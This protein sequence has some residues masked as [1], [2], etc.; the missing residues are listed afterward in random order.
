MRWISASAYSS[1]VALLAAVAAQL[2]GWTGF[3][4]WL[5]LIWTI[6]LF[7]T[8]IGLFDHP[9]RGPAWGLFVGFW[10]GV[11][12]LWLVAIQVFAVADVL[13]EPAYGAWAA[14]PL[15]LI[16]IWFLV[17]S[18]LGWGNDVY[19]GLVD[20]LGILTGAGLL[21]VSVAIWTG[22]A[23]ATRPGAALTAGLYVLYAIGLG[24]IFWA[25]PTRAEPLRTAASL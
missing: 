16:G 3:R 17:A 9:M 18:L 2:L 22:L 1:A 8:V 10:G 13:H 20:A 24:L 6:L 11:G 14:W 4:A 5:L 7:F 25:S 15:A 12:A 23:S 19:P 21:G